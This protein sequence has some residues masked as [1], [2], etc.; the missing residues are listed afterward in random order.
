MT[1]IF[2]DPVAFADEAIAGF[3]AAHPDRVIRVDGGVIRAAASRPG[4]V[5]V[6]IGGGSGHYPAFAGLV[7]VGLSAGAVCGNVFASPSAGQVYRVARAAESGGG[8]LFS[9]GNYAGDVMQFG[10]AQDR[11]RSE[12]IDTRTVVVTDDIASAPVGR[13]GDRRGI[14]GDFTVFKIAGAAAEA[15]LSLEEVEQLARKANSQTRTL[16]VAFRGCTLPGA[17]EPLFSLP[18]GQMS[19]GLG[20]HGEP[21]ISDMEI[22]PA[23]ELAELLVGRLLTETPEHHWDKAVVLVNGL[24]T[25]KYEELFLL[26]GKVA[27]LLAAAGVHIV[28]VECGELVTSLDMSGLSLTLFWVDDELEGLWF[29]PVDTPAYRRG[30]VTPGEIRRVIEADRT[31]AEAGEQVGEVASAASRQLADSAVAILDAVADVMRAHE[32]E[33]GDFDAVAGDGDH[34]IGM[35]R[36]ADAAAEA[37]HAALIRGAGVREL[38]MDAGEQWS[39][40]AGGTSGALWGAALMA[41]ARSLDNRD[42]YHAE[43]LIAAA[44]MARDAVVG[45]GGAV[46]GDKTMVDAMSPYVDTLTLHISREKSVSKALKLAAEAATRAASDTAALRPRKGRARPLAGRSLGTPDPGAVSFALIV[47]A[48]AEL[49]DSWPS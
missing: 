14:A 12:G 25:V 36:G 26:Y 4:Q 34:G 16:G 35:R 31:P 47:K 27:V 20:I 49:A 5:A 28:G 21:G 32:Q 18:A 46:P 11:L 45:L 40:R 22:P 2:D 24:G 30:T 42:A 23:S 1:R 43:D 19:V 48:I 44:A 9:Y 17:A 41:F 8:V 7:G 3:V 13:I 15:G 10:L 39:E 37:A 29:F 6:V 33:L 38:L